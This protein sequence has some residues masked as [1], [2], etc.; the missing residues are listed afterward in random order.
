[1][2]G[3]DIC[4]TE[5]V[6]SQY[7]DDTSFLLDGSDKSLNETLKELNFFSV[8]SGLKINFDKSCAVWL[9][10]KNIVHALLK[11]NLKFVGDKDNSNYL[12]SLFM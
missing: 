9:G 6:I 11:Q 8:L 10:S 5:H 1:M 2:K 4:C 3:I 7:A 12:E